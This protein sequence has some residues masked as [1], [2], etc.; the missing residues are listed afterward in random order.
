[1]TFVLD[2]CAVLALLRKEPGCLKVRDLLA[3]GGN[4]CLIHAV[5]LCEVYYD[6]LRSYGEESAEQMLGGVLAAGLVLR[7]DM[8]VHFWKGAGKLKA[9]GRISLADTFAVM[10]AARDG[11]TL[12]TSDHHEFDP[13]L[14]EG[15]FPVKVQFIR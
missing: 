11:A 4:E 14:K 7:D 6:C 15:N 12:V 2:A 3:D 5:N 1:M 8:D 9:A 10:L 13:L